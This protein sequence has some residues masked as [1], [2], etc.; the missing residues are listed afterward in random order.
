MNSS[1]TEA[2]P[3]LVVEDDHQ[4]LRTIADILRLSGYDPISSSTGTDALQVASQSAPVAVA[5][6]DLRLPDMDGIDLI[7]RLHE[8][9]EITQVV[10]LTGN[11]SVD[12]AVRAMRERS[13]D[14]LV[15]PVD[16]EQLLDSIGRAGER[17]QRKRAEIAM[18]DSEERLRRIFDHSHDALIITDDDDRL[19]DANRAAS[20]FIGLDHAALRTWTLDGLLLPAARGSTIDGS[21]KIRSGEWTLNN[22]NGRTLIVDVRGASFAPGL[23]VHTI[24][25]LTEQRRLE[26]E[27]HHSQKMDSIGRLAGG[28]AHDFNNM[29]TAIGCYTEMLREDFAPG[30]RRR[31]DLEEIMSTT[32]RAAAL[33][34]QLLAFS[35]KQVLQP[36]VLKAN[37][38]VAEIERMLRR[39]IGAHI[40]LTGHSDPNLWSARADPDQLGQVLLNLSINAR[41]AMPNGGTLTIETANVTLPEPVTHR[42]GVVPAGKYVMVRVADTGTG[43]DESTQTQVFDPFFT[44]K[45]PGRGTGL[46]LST[47]YGIVKQSGGHIE[48]QSELNLGT[49]FTV[50]LPQVM[51]LPVEP[52]TGGQVGEEFCEAATILVVE[53]DA[54]VRKLVTGILRRA[55]HTV[56]AASSGEEALELVASHR[57]S[58]ELAILDVVMPGLNGRQ[59]AEKLATLPNSPVV[60][61]MSGYNDDEVIHRGV[62]DLESRFLQKPFSAVQ[63]RQKVAEVLRR[64]RAVSDPADTSTPGL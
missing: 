51:G 28:V 22:V 38:V 42:H 26:D 57:E 40:T 56:L 18:K 34:G 14:Y 1:L 37:I 24:R 52:T 48:L 33:T 10:I 36:R 27:L 63:L 11:A 41:D 61:Y 9:S 12:S 55:G 3:I 29:L 43:M 7:T 64:A 15:K 2:L 31:E 62:R 20:E 35:R 13:Y 39:V 17:W 16:P 23:Y 25:D 59:I 21:S 46:G 58:I 32:R 50:Y 53:D 30:D 4:L 19:V 6:V 45:A 5:L 60:M 8:V 47:A 44:T 54:S 49:T